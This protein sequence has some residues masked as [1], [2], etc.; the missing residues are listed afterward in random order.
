MDPTKREFVLTLINNIMLVLGIGVIGSLVIEYGYYVSDSTLRILHYYDYGVL[1]LFI[2]HDLLKLAIVSDKRTFLRYN[3]LNFTFF[4]GLFLFFLVYNPWWQ[5]PLLSQEL[6]DVP[7]RKIAKIFIL[8]TQVYI[9]F[10]TFFSALKFGQKFAFSRFQPIT[11]LLG[12]FAVIILIGT[13]LLLLPKATVPSDISFVDALFTSTSATCVTGLIVVDTGTYFTRFGQWVILLLM[14]AGGLGIMTM[15]ALFVAVLGSKMSIHQRF[16]LRDL[17]SDENM[18]KIGQTLWQVL[19]LT[20]FI[21]AIGIVAM[22][23]LFPTNAFPESDRLFISLFHAVSAFCNAGFSTFSNSLMGFEDS[24]ILVGVFAGLIILGGMGFPVLSNMF[25]H[26]FFGTIGPLGKKRVRLNSQTNIVLRVSGVLIVGGALWIW[27]TNYGYGAG[28]TLNFRTIMHSLFQSITSRTAG[29]NTIDIGGMA[30]PAIL[31]IMALMFIGASPGSTGGG[32][33]TTT[34]FLSLQ[35]LW[36]QLRGKRRVEY[37]YM[38]IPSRLLQQSLIL[39]LAAQLVIG[40]SFIL[41]TIF[42]SQDVMVLFFEAVSAFGTV[43]LSMGATPEL[44][45]VGRVIITLTMYLGRVGPLALV[46]ALGKSEQKQLY[47]YPEESVMIG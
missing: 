3:W 11:L 14:Q 6:R 15:A 29:F 42:E 35:A 26:R 36:G 38:T 13:G 28:W 22:Y 47:E 23:E 27:L 24:S 9:L 25:G 16:V 34:F 46:I 30:L 43:G 41:L 45:D 21:E 7:V 1:F 17:L 2:G 33:K 37:R 32:I 20:V 40:I 8:L 39:I 5:L 12:S 18:S 31:G 10:A 19:G 4:A 44:T